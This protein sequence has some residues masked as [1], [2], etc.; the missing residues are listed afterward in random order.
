MTSSEGTYGGTDERVLVLLPESRDAESIPR[1]LEVIGVAS[2][3]CATQ[4]ELCA[5]IQRGAGALMIEEEALSPRV[6]SCLHATLERQPSWSELPVIILSSRGPETQVAR[7]AL[8]LPGDVTLVERP[9]RVNTLVSR[10][11]SALRSRRRQYL[12][13]DQLQALEQSGTR[14]AEQAAE[15]DGLNREL[16]TFN[17]T[18]AHDL[19]KPLAVVNGYCQILQQLCG[20]KLDEECT[21]YI[22]DAYDATLRMNRLIDTLLMF[23][24]LAHAEPKIERLELCPMCEE[25]ASELRRA[26]P[27]RHVTFRILGG[28]VAEGDP[29]LMRVVL[30]NLF[31][32]AW[33]YTGNREEAVIEFGATEVDGKRAY[34][35]RDNGIGFDPAEADKLFAPF[36]RLER[37]KE[38]EGL[39]IGLAT[40]A[41]IIQRHGGKVWAE[42]E[43]GKGTTFYFTLGS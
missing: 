35:V 41:R 39:G 17:Y 9:V 26:E 34:F 20:D 42:G 15:L 21:G 3:M 18:V 1:V 43:P 8:Q 12:V 33:K 4:E 22:Q 6:G 38:V 27:E 28:I 10:V 2:M 40:V 29:D 24:R 7:D 11:R 23:S 37:D 31:G 36:E 25:I 16:E 19:R 14:L 13:R 30:S 32:N 5:E